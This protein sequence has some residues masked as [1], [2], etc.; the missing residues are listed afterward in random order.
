MTRRWML[1]GLIGAVCGLGILSAAEPSPVASGYEA[2]RRGDYHRAVE[3]FA[4]A[5]NGSHGSRAAFGMGAA[6]YRLERYAEAEACYRQAGTQAPRAQAAYNAG[7]CALRQALH[8]RESPDPAL[9]ARACQHYREALEQAP[10]ASRL[11]ADARHN[12]ELATLL[13][14]RAASET[15]SDA[16]PAQPGRDGA[17]PPTEKPGQ[18]GSPPLPAQDPARDPATGEENGGQPGKRDSGKGQEA[19]APKAPEPPPGG[20]CAAPT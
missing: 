14:A 5:A 19:A 16:K 4:R 12:L 18:A 3:A 6:L 7:T 8:Q 13:H 17:S 1:R 10:A 2:Y 11:A 15:P 9:L 20:A